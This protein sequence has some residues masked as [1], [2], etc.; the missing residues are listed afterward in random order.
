MLRSMTTNLGQHGSTTT[1]GMSLIIELN[2]TMGFNRR[3]KGYDPGNARIRPIVDIA[4]NGLGV[5]PTPV[6]SSHC[7][8]SEFPNE[9][10]PIISLLSNFLLL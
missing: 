2:G 6:T 4:F 9:V 3:L 1:C 10:P 8:L 7:D 5:C